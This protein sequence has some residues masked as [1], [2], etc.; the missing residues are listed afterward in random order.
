MQRYG[1]RDKLGMTLKVNRC[2]KNLARRG[3]YRGSSH[4]QKDG[5]TLLKK[6]LTQFLKIILQTPKFDIGQILL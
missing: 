5:I 3:Q 4:D 2:L 6:L 1:R